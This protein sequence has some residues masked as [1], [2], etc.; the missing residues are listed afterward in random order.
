MLG[1]IPYE[2]RRLQE[3]GELL[4][5]GEGVDF[6]CAVA[7]DRPVEDQV[8][9]IVDPCPGPHDQLVGIELPLRQRRGAYP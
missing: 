6:P 1:D 4:C 7:H 2:L 5:E 8:Q 9:S 3:G